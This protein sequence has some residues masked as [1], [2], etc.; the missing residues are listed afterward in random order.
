MIFTL[1]IIAAL[2]LAFC[3]NGLLQPSHFSVSRSISINRI[4]ETVFPLIED[5]KSWD[6]WSPW[7]EKDPA[8]TKQFSD[9][10][11]GVGA[12]YMWDGNKDVGK[13]KMTI[14]DITM[15]KSVSINLDIETP[16]EAHNNV[17]FSLQSKNN[18]TIATWQMSGPQNFVM[19][20][21]SY[22]F[23]MDRMVG[24]D[25]ETGLRSLKALVED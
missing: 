6:A 14:T 4:P 3:V 13:G 8:M 10:S 11:D 25:F 19:R 5:L 1:C 9:P 17:L 22:F 12:S 2:A 18:E 7:A 23:N 15:H 20:A 16:F 24:K 21:L